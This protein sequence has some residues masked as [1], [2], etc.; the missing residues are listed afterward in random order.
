MGTLGRHDC[1]VCVCVYSVKET[2]TNQINHCANLSEKLLTML[3]YLFLVQL[4]FKPIFR[5]T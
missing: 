4:A 1:W 5:S 3:A 2:T